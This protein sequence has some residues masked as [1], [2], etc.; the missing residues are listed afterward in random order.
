M[1]SLLKKLA[2]LTA[3]AALALVL[4]SCN[5][6]T[7]NHEHTYSEEWTCDETNHWHKATCE[8]TDEVSA[9]AE[10]DFG[11]WTEVTAATEEDEGSKERECSVCGYKETATI[12]KLAHTHKFAAEWT[13]DKTNHWHKAT[14]DHT[15]EVDGKAEHSYGDWTQVKAATEEDEGSK[16]RE[17]SVCGYKETAKIAKLSHT[18]KFS[19]DWS[20]D[21]TN[22]WHAAT[23]EHTDEKSDET[24]HT[25]N[26][27]ICSVCGYEKPI[28]IA[29]T[30]TYGS[31]EYD[32]PN[33]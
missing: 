20:Y 27:N 25:Y 10:H 7:D 8:H 19:K 32:E 33:N 15:D 12:E 13:N 2:M 28:N 9:L 18:H 11:E 4:V 22:H 14:C 26:D 21:K 5:T 1:K 29:V 31:N 17:C 24:E 3:L 23:C 16:K 30:I 6:H